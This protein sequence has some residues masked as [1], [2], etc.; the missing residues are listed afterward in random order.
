MKEPKRGCPGRVGITPA[1]NPNRREGESGALKL[2]LPL[3]WEAERYGPQPGL[4]TG[5]IWPDAA[6]AW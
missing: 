1:R 2:E 4:G 3:A 6:W 5:L